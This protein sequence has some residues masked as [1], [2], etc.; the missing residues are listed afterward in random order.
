MIALR[1]FPDGVPRRVAPPAENPLEPNLFGFYG[2][3]RM[4]EIALSEYLRVPGHQPYAPVRIH[5]NTMQATLPLRATPPAKP[6]P[7]AVRRHLTLEEL[8]RR[9]AASQEQGPAKLIPGTFRQVKR[10]RSLTQVEKGLMMLVAG[11]LGLSIW[12]HA[13]PVPVSAHTTYYRSLAATTRLAAGVPRSFAESALQAL[14]T[15]WHAATFFACVHP[16]FWKRGATVH[17][18]TRAAR[19]ELG[20]ARLAE[21]GPVVSVLSFPATTG[22]TTE[23]VDGVDSL[24]GKVSGQLEQAD[25]TVVR[26]T[27]HLVQDAA[28]RRWSLIELSIPGFLP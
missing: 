20:L 7:G 25:G 13:L 14:G 23:M 6:R 19:I 15:D 10:G 8:L 11:G 3:V 2:F 1:H 18:N 22:V 17:P 24:V 28:T 5:P 16:S 27:A 12:L 9:A 4:A 21:H 26:F